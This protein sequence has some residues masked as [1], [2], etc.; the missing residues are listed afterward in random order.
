MALVP[1]QVEDHDLVELRC[2]HTM[3]GIIDTLRGIIEVKCRS[4]FCGSRSGIVVLHQ[5]D[6]DTGVLLQTEKFRDPMRGKEVNQ[7]GDA[8]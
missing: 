8:G 2:P 5:F 7:D 6:L 3:H 4:S 1:V